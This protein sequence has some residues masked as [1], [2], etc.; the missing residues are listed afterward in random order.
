MK[1]CRGNY[2][3]YRCTR[4]MILTGLM[5]A[6]GKVLTVPKGHPWPVAPK[7]ASMPA[8]RT[9]QQ[10]LRKDLLPKCIKCT[11]IYYAIPPGVFMHKEHCPYISAN[12]YIRCKYRRGEAISDETFH[13]PRNGNT[14]G[15]ITRRAC[16]DGTPASDF[17]G[18]E[19]WGGH[20]SPTA[21]V[22]YIL[23]WYV[24]LFHLCVT[25]P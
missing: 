1:N 13:R 4:V 5:L 11:L 9:F 21:G 25:L 14:P 23:L 24:A 20:T 2:I 3:V 17:A 10:S 12:T 18:F 16:R 15:K 7:P 19:R 6:F 8:L 22:F